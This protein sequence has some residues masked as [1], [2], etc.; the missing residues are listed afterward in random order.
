MPS[1][2]VI[3]L[4]NQGTDEGRQDVVPQEEDVRWLGVDG[5]ELERQPAAAP[6]NAIA[7]S[8]SAPMTSASTSVSVGYAVVN[9]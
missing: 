2:N 6:S 1:S 7:D 5:Y 8:S 9:P 4:M 3:N